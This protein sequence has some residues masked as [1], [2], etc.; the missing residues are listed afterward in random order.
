[1]QLVERIAERQIELAPSDW[2]AWC[3]RLEQTLV[4][5]VGTPGVT[6]FT[7]LGVNPLAP[8]YLRA[9]RPTFAGDGTTPAG[10][11]YEQALE[12]VEQAWGVHGLR[13]VGQIA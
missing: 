12:R 5:S 7:G 13:G 6:A 8:L 10:Q 11:Q 9:F 4:R 2:A 3:H 1:M